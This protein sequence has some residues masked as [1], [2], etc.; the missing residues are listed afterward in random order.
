MIV[1]SRVC[2]VWLEVG[3]CGFRFLGVWHLAM[4]NDC[5]GNV[6]PSLRTLF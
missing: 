3:V 5:D 2:T 1:V 6:H 4:C